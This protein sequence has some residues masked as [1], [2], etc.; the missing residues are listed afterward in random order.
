MYA[1]TTRIERIEWQSKVEGGPHP[2]RSRFC[3]DE[4]ADIC[5]SA[6]TDEPRSPQF[7]MGAVSD[8]NA[9]M[10]GMPVSDKQVG[11]GEGV[12]FS[13]DGA[14]NSRLNSSSYLAQ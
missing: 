4:E 13:S 8:W 1:V 7:C 5:Y 12:L 3:L 10:H 11:N 6:G 2:R 14:G 9:R